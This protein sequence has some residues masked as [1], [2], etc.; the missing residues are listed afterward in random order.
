MIMLKS[1]CLDMRVQGLFSRN[2][3]CGLQEEYTRIE[4][5]KKNHAKK[6]KTTEFEVKKQT[7]I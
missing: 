5:K 3:D 2:K 1:Q 7:K 6:K 4:K